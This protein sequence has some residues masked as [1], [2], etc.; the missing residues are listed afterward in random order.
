MS[1]LNYL[2][3]M[4]EDETLNLFNIFLNFENSTNKYQD[5]LNKY[6]EKVIKEIKTKKTEYCITENLI[7]NY[8]KII[9]KEL[10]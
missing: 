2:D 6:K 3:N 1:K 7:K 10:R 8:A 4:I 5:I 9:L